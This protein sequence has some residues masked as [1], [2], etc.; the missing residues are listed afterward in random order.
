MLGRG[1][2]GTVAFIA[3]FFTDGTAGTAVAINSIHTNIPMIF[4]FMFLFPPSLDTFFL[5]SV[6][7]ERGGRFTIN[8]G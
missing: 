4:V 7:L 1:W 6:C 2:L 5:T 3:L 8:R